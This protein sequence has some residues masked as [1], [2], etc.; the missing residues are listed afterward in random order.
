MSPTQNPEQ[1]KPPTT[2]TFRER[3][4]SGELLFLRNFYQGTLNYSEHERHN[5]DINKLRSDY[6]TDNVVVSNADING[7]PDG[8]PNTVGIYV[9]PQVWTKL[10]PKK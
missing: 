5:N 6:G 2:S 4:A 7:Q 8:Q 1:L 9:T 10:H 3:V